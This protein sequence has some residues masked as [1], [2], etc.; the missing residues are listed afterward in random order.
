MKQFEI[1]QG[2]CLD[3][4]PSLAGRNVSLVLADLPYGVTQQKWDE[5]IPFGPLW[6]GLLNSTAPDSVFVFTATQPFTSALVMSQPRLFKYDWT[7]KKPKGT[8]H[9]N[10][11]RQ[12]MRDKEDVLVFAKGKPN[13]FPQMTEGKPYKARGGKRNDETYG[14]YAST[15]ND[16]QGLRY[17]K[18]VQEWPIVERNKFHES[19]KPQELLRYMIRTYTSPG[20]I[21]L[22]PTM[23]GGSAGVAALAEGRRF[24]GV[25]K[26]AGFFEVCRKRL[27]STG[28]D[29]L[30]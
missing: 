17:P 6:E 11:K 19:E 4:L 28:I 9:L 5:V 2:D 22:D 30:L 24:I 21:V 13:Y 12:P 20:D 14:N 27:E 25:E 29:D 26:D 3:V 23:G 15:R 8:G 18:Q 10:A 7:W 1:Y 16:N